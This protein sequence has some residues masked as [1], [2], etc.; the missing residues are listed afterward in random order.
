LKS[1]ISNLSEIFDSLKT[2]PPTEG[3]QSAGF[4]I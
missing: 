3:Y 2:N 1:K 4:R